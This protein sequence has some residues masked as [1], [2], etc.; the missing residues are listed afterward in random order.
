MCRQW[1]GGTVYAAPDSACVHTLYTVIVNDEIAW[2]LLCQTGPL[3]QVSKYKVLEVEQEGL[4]RK[5]GQVSLRGTLA[6]DHG[7]EYNH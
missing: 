2:G 6:R 4:R 7:A 1:K 5:E 3:D